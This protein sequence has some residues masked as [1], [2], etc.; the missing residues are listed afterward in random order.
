MSGSGTD[1]QPEPF[2]LDD[3]PIG[4]PVPVATEP[5]TEM[6]PSDAMLWKARPLASRM[7]AAVESSVCEPKVMLP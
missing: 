1:P 6:W 2:E 5:P 7:R 3:D 4:E